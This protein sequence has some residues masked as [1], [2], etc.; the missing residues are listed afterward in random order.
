M[1]IALDTRTGASALVRRYL[2]LMEARKLDE[3]RGMLADGFTMTFPGAVTFERPEELVE[4]AKPRYRFVRKT[5]ENFDEA[6][7]SGTSV[8]YCTGTLSG[9]LPD[10]T[11]FEGIR[12]I[13]RFT[14]RGGLLIDQQV[15]NDFAE[16]MANR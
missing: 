4:W 7:D 2:D 8:V 13:D 10:G 14:V 12:F 9:E 16:V 3:A 6:A 5:Y 11:A 15:W 1:T